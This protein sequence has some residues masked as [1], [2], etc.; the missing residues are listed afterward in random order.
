MHKVKNIKYSIEGYILLNL[1]K[2]IISFFLFLYK[3]NPY[4]IKSIIDTLEEKHDTM[5]HLLEEEYNEYYEEFGEDLIN[6]MPEIRKIKCKYAI[7]MLD[8]MEDTIEKFNM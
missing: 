2:L 4:A 8:Y 7:R 5:E 3:Y 6:K 1:I